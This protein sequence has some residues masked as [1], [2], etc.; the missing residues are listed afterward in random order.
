VLERE[1]ITI[2]GL[3]STS[4]EALRLV[5]ELRPDVTLVDIALGKESGLDLSQQLAAATF[6]DRTTVILM[7]TRAEE[8]VVPMIGA[9]SAAAFLQKIDISGK[10]IREIHGRS[11]RR[12]SARPRDVP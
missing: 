3:A 9:G 5:D 11:Q 8:D 7:S 6:T 4:A 12:G 10:A 2:I 1:G